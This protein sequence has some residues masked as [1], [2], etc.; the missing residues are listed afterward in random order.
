LQFNIP[1]EDYLK[2][3]EMFKFPAWL[4]EN[5]VGEFYFLI[6]QMTNVEVSGKELKKNILINNF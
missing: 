2:L 5:L 4:Q 1:K 3:K 6:Q